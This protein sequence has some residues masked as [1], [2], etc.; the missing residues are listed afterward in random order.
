MNESYKTQRLHLLG[1]CEKTHG[2][3]WVWGKLLPSYWGVAGAAGPSV[4]MVPLSSGAERSSLC[5]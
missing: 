5:H 3:A 4:P 2:C 1:T